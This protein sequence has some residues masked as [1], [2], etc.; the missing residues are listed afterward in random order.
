VI[1]NV[2]YFSVPLPRFDCTSSTLVS[3]RF[4]RK[5]NPW[6][7]AFVKSKETLREV[8]VVQKR[9]LVLL[10]FVLSFQ[11]NFA[12]MQPQLLHETLITA[13]SQYNTNEPQLMTGPL[14]FPGRIY[15]WP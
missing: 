3:A 4:D 1:A 13:L 10:H 5:G 6:L 9:S 11:P 8:E 2:K 15:E 12:H 14:S 7:I